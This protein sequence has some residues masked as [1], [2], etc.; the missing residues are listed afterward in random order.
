[1][2]DST[3]LLSPKDVLT[4]ALT[5]HAETSREL[6]QS[7]H[8]HASNYLGRSG[9]TPG[10]L[11]DHATRLLTSGALA[12]TLFLASPGLS[13]SPPPN[14][15]KLAQL[16]LA[17]RQNQFGNTVKRLLPLAMQ[18]LTPDQ[19]KNIAN[20]IYD[21][22]GINA[23]AVFQGERL[24]RSYGFIGAEQHLPRFPGDTEDQH[25]AYPEKGVTPGRGAWGYF[26]NSKEAVTQDIIEKEKWYVAVQT[27]YLPDW[28]SRL[29]YLRDWYKYRKVVLVNPVNGKII[30]CDVADSGPS[31]WTGKHF[32]GS[33]EVM[34]YLGLNVGMQKGP[35]VLFFL[36]DPDNKV[37]L[38]PVEK[39]MAIGR[40]I[41]E[42]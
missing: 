7:R 38:G 36:D 30:I 24:N 5:R 20:I 4:K 15:A 17:E 19:E 16:T 9:L 18:P 21:Y 11:R 3:A 14:F 8:P 31:D 27:L 34:A 32:G 33:P 1:M 37:P 13:H 26:A 22:W 25:D 2:A 28:N 41:A 40:D 29:R 23:K 42:R 10:T 39:P 35:V 6:F 12:G